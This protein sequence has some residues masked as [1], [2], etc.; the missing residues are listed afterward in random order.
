MVLPELILLGFPWFL[1]P[2]NSTGPE[3]KENS[4]CFIVL[5]STTE[6]SLWICFILHLIIPFP[7]YHLLS[8]TG[9]KQ[10]LIIATS[11]FLDTA[12]ESFVELM[13]ISTLDLIHMIAI[14]V[15]AYYSLR[16]E[17]ILGSHACHGVLEKLGI[18]HCLVGSSPELV[19]ESR[20][21]VTGEFLVYHKLS[22]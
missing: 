20:F 18:T 2:P 11:F 9:N 4:F 3:R 13:L 15:S 17:R 22:V 12:S 7:V 8:T 21:H 14:P 10:L 6:N 19:N 5:S 1:A 16:E